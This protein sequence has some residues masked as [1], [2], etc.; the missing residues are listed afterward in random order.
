MKNARSCRAYRA[1]SAGS[2]QV[3]RAPAPPT[4]FVPNEFAPLAG[5]AWVSVCFAAL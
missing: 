4:S 5:A 2:R 1:F 3:F